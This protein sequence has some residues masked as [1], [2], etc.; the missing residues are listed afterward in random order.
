MLKK[1]SAGGVVVNPQGKILVTNRYGHTW[2]LPKGHIDEGEDEISAAKRE[3]MEETGVPQEKLELIKKL[4]SYERYKIGKNPATED[5]SELK[6]L[7]FYLFKTNYI[8]LSPIDKTHNQAKWVEID[9]VSQL[10]TH[11]KD[12]EFFD[13]IKDKI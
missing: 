10:L 5:R 3:I 9:K 12:R 8:H 4:G 6:E 1:I 13:K 7:V 2:T 11:P